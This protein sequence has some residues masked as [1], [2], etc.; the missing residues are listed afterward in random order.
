M[1]NFTSKG[2]DKVPRFIEHGNGR[3]FHFKQIGKFEYGRISIFG[4][5][6]DVKIII[7][8]FIS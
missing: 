1:E 5:S 7:I 4:R 6:K 8:L 3:H 2:I